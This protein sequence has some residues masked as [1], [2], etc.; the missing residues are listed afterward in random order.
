M[1]QKG[2]SFPKP[3][4]KSRGRVK[5]LKIPP[6]Q[7]EGQELNA[8]VVGLANLETLQVGNFESHLENIKQLLSLKIQCFKAGNI[9]K[10]Y[11]TWLE[12]TSNPEVLYTVKGQSIE[13]TPTPYQDQVPAQKK[14][15]AEE[16]NLIQCEINKLLQ[17]KVIKSTSHEPGQFIST[18]FLRPKRDGTHRI[19]L[20]LKKL[21]KSVKYEHFKMDTLWTVIRMMKHSCYMAYIDIKD[22][23]YSVPIA[24]TDQKYLTFEWRGVLYKFTCFPNNGLALCPRKFTKLLKPVYC[25]L[26]KKGHLSSGCIDDSYLQ[27]D[28]YQDCLAN[29]LDTIKL[30]HWGS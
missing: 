25:Y 6:L 21:N 13:F 12:L 24:D 28:G 10:F 30:I 1:G 19:I 9:S 27:G 14:F 11:S 26:R 5:K 16:N 22:V 23:Y 29:F 7:K 20:N 18:I 17:K 3:L 15:S 8:N 2:L 4:P